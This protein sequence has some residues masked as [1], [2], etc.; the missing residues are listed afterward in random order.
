MKV[1]IIGS[2][3]REHAITWACNRSSLH[4]KL[5]CAPGN[6][7]T[8]QIA[9]NVNI[10]ADA[11]DELVDFVRAEKFDLTVIGPEAP[12]VAGLA[13]RL[14]AY[15]YPVFGPSA[16][17][18]QIEGSKA[19]AKE[20]MNRVGIPTAGYMQFS[21]LDR[22]VNCIKEHE[23]PLVVKASGLAA[24]KGAVVCKSVDEAMGIAEAML[25]RRELGEAG[26]VIIVEDFLRGREVSMTAIADGE[27]FLLLPP[28]RD[29]KRVFDDDQ[30]PN[31]GGMGAYSPLEDLPDSLY[32]TAA[33]NILTRLLGA[34]NDDCTPF[35]G[36]IYPGLMVEG[37]DY[38]VLEV[39]ARFGDPEMQVLAPLFSFD[40]LTVMSEAAH[41]SLSDWMHREG[42]DSYDWRRTTKQG[43]AATIVAASEGYPG[44][45]RKGVTINGIPDENEDLV[46]FHAGT[47][48]V[49]S[50]VETSGGR[51]LAV[52]G[53]GK[54]TT[55]AAARAYSALE[56]ISFE[57]MHYRRDIGRR[58]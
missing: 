48:A 12:L 19:F 14:R 55:E 36:V 11:I 37:N 56:S 5:T 15:G 58:R 42:L 57:G 43:G 22:A 6:G 25:G 38:Y 18:A 32:C 31:T 39:N 46:V 54:D 26:D 28:S 27:D 24:G 23:A 30:G 16:K 49:N 52:T 1:L 13:D 45:I 41:H 8:T 20:L 4:P 17:A 40:L 10:S 9:R 44:K 47:K 29:H 34:F 35:N 7:G 51:V 50:G 3:G 53:L 2:G 21:E 33:G